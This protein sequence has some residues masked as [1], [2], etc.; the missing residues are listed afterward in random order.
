NAKIEKEA[1]D[2]SEPKPIKIGK[3]GAI[4]EGEQSKAGEKSGDKSHSEMDTTTKEEAKPKPKPAE[5]GP[6]PKV[7][8]LNEKEEKI[9]KGAV[10]K[11]ADYPTLADIES[12]WDST[13]ER[14]K[15]KKKEEE[16][17]KRR[18]S[19]SRDKTVP[20]A[21]TPDNPDGKAS[22]ERTQNTRNTAEGKDD[23]DMANLLTQ[24]DTTVEQKEADA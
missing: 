19:N 9:R 18:S 17:K 15:E 24:M 10:R 21:V 4:I 5:S 3:D 16:R 7:F 1:S 11:P 6:K 22:V 20:T 2:G 14:E 12:D 23:A 8:P 13:K